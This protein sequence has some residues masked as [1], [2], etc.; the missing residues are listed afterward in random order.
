MATVGSCLLAGM[1]FSSMNKFAVLVSSN[2]GSVRM[3]VHVT[4]VPNGDIKLSSNVDP[5]DYILV[6]KLVLDAH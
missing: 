1:L 2:G 6:L 5:F 3:L 4:I